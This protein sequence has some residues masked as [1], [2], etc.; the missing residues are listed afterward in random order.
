MNEEARAE[1]EVTEGGR[2]RKRVGEEI[3][4]SSSI[5]IFIFC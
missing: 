3:R 1:M 4:A 2:G 5:F